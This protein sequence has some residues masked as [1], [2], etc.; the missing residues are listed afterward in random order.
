MCWYR[1]FRWAK[2]RKQTSHLKGLDPVWIRL[3]CFKYSLEAKL[4]PQVSHMKG[5]SPKKGGKRTMKPVVLRML[6]NIPQ[7]FWS[8]L[9]LWGPLKVTQ[10]QTIPWQ[11]HL[12]L[13]QVAPRHSQPGLEQF[14]GWGVH[15]FF[16]KTVPGP[17][18]SHREEFLPKIQFKS[19]LPQLKITG[20]AWEP[21]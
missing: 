4:F 6:L 10:F 18:Y 3:W 14:L 8:M 21:F 11:G 19:T 15:S 2:V 1:E 16:G 20:Y 9:S 13:S 12:P 17:H 7:K 5:L